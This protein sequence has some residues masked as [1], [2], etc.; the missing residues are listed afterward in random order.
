MT[1]VLIIDDEQPARQIIANYLETVS[2]I[3][4]IG[5][6]SDGFSAV[7]TI[8]EQKPD[9]IFLDIQM[10]KLDGFEVLELAEHKPVVIFSTAYDSFAVKAFEQN[11][12]DYLL[13]P[14]SK[15]R[16]LEALSKGLEK[17]KQKSEH[18]TTISN[19]IRYKD[20]H[21]EILTKIAIKNGSKI[22][23]IPTADIFFLESDGDYVYIHTKDKKFVKEKT[24]K[25]FETHLDTTIFIR[26]HRSYMV[27]S[28]FIALIENYDKENYAVK[29]V[30]QKTIKASVSGY[31][32]L[33]EILKF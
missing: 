24:M 30:N 2:G 14:Y 12:V 21:T 1:R 13:K 31:K 19:L 28:N 11:A 15:Q 5:E 18:E 22:D 6:C 4:L 9:L 27:N 20:E 33:K 10:P 7:K 8:N 25:Y 16:F 3:E 26:V 32:I 23:V 29:L 17:L